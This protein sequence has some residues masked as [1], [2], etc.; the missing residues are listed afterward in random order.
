[1]SHDSKS[2]KELTYPFAR[3]VAERVSRYFNEVLMAGGRGQSSAAPA[4]EVDA[5]AAMID[6]GFWASL[7]RE[8][9]FAPKISLVYLPPTQPIAPLV[10][11]RPLPL[12]PE[13]LT[14]LA[15]A[16]ERPNIHLGVWRSGRDMSVW[17]ATR[18][19]PP[20]CFV[21]EVA[22]P[23]VLVVKHS[24]SDESGKF[25]NFAVLEGDRV[26]MLDRGATRQPDSPPLLAALL[27]VEE[28]SQTAGLETL[29]RLAVSMR[30][31][32]HGGSLLVV[33]AQSERWRES[34]IQPI[35]Y[36]VAPPFTRLADLMRAPTGDGQGQQWQEKLQRT[37]DGIAGLTAV[38]GATVMDDRLAVLAFGANIRRRDGARQVE[39]V[40]LSEPIEGDT[41]R[42]LGIVQLGGT[43]H[44]SA[45]QFVQDQQDAVAMVASQD[46]RFTLFGWSANQSSVCAYRVESF[47]M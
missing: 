39:Q 16:V 13:E 29:A 34:V 33:P 36:P 18:M 41:P 17:G 14:R 31:H 30:S 40:V 35:R 23:G 42:T 26:K 22:S 37:I 38:D 9:G 3:A 27:G 15:P 2:T 47:L 32:G 24:R 28:T 25:V 19:I 5:L 46:G 8:E 20:F 7:R 1:M 10:L 43:R 11:G 44:L 6:A 21:L 45:A 12:T 4:P